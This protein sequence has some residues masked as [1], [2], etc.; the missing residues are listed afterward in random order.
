MIAELSFSIHDDHHS[1]SRSSCLIEKIKI[2][3][4]FSVRHLITVNII[5]EALFV[6]VKNKI[7]YCHYEEAGN[8][9][10]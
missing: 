6:E 1:V 7:N 8:H 4:F 5:R 2:S 3:S 9:L 10:S